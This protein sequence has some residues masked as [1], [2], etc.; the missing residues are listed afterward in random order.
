LVRP[1]TQAGFGP[2]MRVAAQTW[3]SELAQRGEW[4]EKLIAC[5]SS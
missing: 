5:R 2:L 3:I 1:P 4:F